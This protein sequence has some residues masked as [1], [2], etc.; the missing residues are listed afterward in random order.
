M[1]KAEYVELWYNQGSGI[2][3]AILNYKYM[4]SMENRIKKLELTIP[5]EKQVTQRG[6]YLTKLT[7]SKR[8]EKYLVIKTYIQ[9]LEERLDAL[10]QKMQ[11]N[12]IIDSFKNRWR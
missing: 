3:K 7:Q 8:K 4:R 10:T 11:L 1:T 2:G 5:L 6:E 12:D 9:E